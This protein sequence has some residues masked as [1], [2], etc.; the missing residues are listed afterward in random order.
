[1][2]CGLCGNPQAILEH[3]RGGRN[4][5]KRRSANESLAGLQAMSNQ[6]R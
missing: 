1:M 3:K 4:G 6:R 2:G 5:A